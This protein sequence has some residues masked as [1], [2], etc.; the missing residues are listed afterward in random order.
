MA[1]V[2]NTHKTAPK[3]FKS[4][5]YSVKLHYNSPP[6]PRSVAEQVTIIAWSLFNQAGEAI[7]L[8]LKFI[9]LSPS[10]LF[11]FYYSF[12]L[13]LAIYDNRLP[14]GSTLS[15]PTKLLYRWF[16]A[17][18][19][20]DEIVRPVLPLRQAAFWLALFIVANNIML[21]SIRQTGDNRGM[22][23][24]NAHQRGYCRAQADGCLSR[25]DDVAQAYRTTSC[26]A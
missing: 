13:I 25:D 15:A 5:D 17:S 8:A 14:G 2:E 3:A 26:R 23:H 10:M 21:H 20:P 6:R 1:R 12:R 9:P 22:P 18:N 24:P 16:S 19:H 4:Y 7:K 11:C